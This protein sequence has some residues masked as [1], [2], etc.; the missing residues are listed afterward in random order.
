MHAHYLYTE[1]NEIEIFYYI[2]LFY[3]L[4]RVLVVNIQIIEF[5]I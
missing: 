3:G 1:A 2:L 5:D 4:L